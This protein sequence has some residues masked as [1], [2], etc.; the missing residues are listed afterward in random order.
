MDPTRRRQS[1]IFPE[2]K[3]EPLPGP[4]ISISLTS[5]GSSRVINHDSE[6]QKILRKMLEEKCETDWELVSVD[7]TEF[8]CHKAV[9]A[10]A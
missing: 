7:G 3:H 1:K 5:P 8:P 9:L 10:G 4:S 2:T 6:I